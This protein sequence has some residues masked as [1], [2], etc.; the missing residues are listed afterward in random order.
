MDNQFLTQEVL[1]FRQEIRQL[2]QEIAS[3][4]K[5]VHFLETYNEDLKQE[6]GVRIKRPKNVHAVTASELDPHVLAKEI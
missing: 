4:R 1:R 3:L 6:M 5:Y 2:N